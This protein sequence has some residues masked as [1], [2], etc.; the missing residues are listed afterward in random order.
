MSQEN[1]A[2][3]QGLIDASGRGD[4]DAL[5]ATL[6]PAVEWTPVESDPGYAVHRGHDEV[7][8]WLVEWSEAFPDMRWEAERILDAGG[9]SVVA[10]VR[11][12]GRGAASGLDL[13]TPAYGVVFTIRSG[14]VV[15]IEEYADRHRALEVVG[16]RE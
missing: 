15:R 12:A 13:E 16:L 10:L 3:V 2:L 8:A 6:D 7:R 4:L 11:M 9:E 1:V 14:K 5:M